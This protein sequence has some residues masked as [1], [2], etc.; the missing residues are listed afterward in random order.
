VKAFQSALSVGG[1]G[2]VPK[3]IEFHA[4]DTI[5]YAGDILA[6]IHQASMGEREMLENI[7]GMESNLDKRKPIVALPSALQDVEGYTTT[8]EEL[9]LVLDRNT[10]TLCP[11]LKVKLIHV[12]TFRCHVCNHSGMCDCL[13][14]PE[15]LSILL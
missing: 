12:E 7:F 4:H 14:S 15:C 6:W 1:P 5:R 8:I 2:G 13:Q 3:P 9:L 11:I 10:E